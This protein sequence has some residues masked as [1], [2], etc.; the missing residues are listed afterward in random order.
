MCESI[1]QEA[2]DMPVC[3]YEQS[4]NGHT[5]ISSIIME[6]KP[7]PTLYQHRKL[8]LVVIAL[9]ALYTQLAIIMSLPARP[10][11]KRKAHWSRDYHGCITSG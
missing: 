8:L 3:Q 11:R 4:F 9:T 6:N 5:P 7:D 10:P 1:L 2:A